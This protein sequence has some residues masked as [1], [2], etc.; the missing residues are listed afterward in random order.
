MHLTGKVGDQKARAE[1]ARRLLAGVQSWEA[2]W[3]GLGEELRTMALLEIGD[4]E[5]WT[6]QLD[7]AEPHLQQAITL[8]RRIERP[9]LEFM[10]LTYRAEIELNRRFPQAEELSKHAIDLAER[11]GWTD[12]LFMGFASMTLGSALTWQG[13]LDEAESWVRRAELTFRAEANPAS[14]MGGHFIRGQLE[15]ARGRFAD[16]LAAFRA[17][18]RL[19]GPHPLARPLRAWL[20]YALAG[21]GETEQAEDV[22]AGLGDP[23]RGRGEMRAAEAVLRLAQE[24]ARAAT[25][26]LE[27][28]LA[29]AVRVSWRAWLAEAFLLEAIARDALGDPGAA[30]Q[31]LERALGLAGQDGTLMWFLLHPAPGLL[32]RQAAQGTAHAALTARILDLLA[33]NSAGPHRAKRAGPRPLLEPL[34]K[35]ELRVLRYLPTHLSAAEIA[36]ELS[37]SASTV[38]THMRNLYPKLDAHRRAEAIEHAR[39]LGLLAPSARPR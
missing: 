13:R 39:A 15:L 3:T 30:G 32:E 12:D 22:L 14:A 1:E 36:R 34:S 9:Y 38:K 7:Q 2:A 26:A 19:A 24:D 23:G 10:G 16:A 20:V 4:A 25:V 11:H 37:V 5:T 27:P 6:G 33:G 31:A 35:S 18:E 29:G 21:L 8:A 17:A 28:F